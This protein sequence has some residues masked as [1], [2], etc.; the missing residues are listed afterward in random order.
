MSGGSPILV[1]LRGN[2]LALTDREHG[3]NFD[4]DANGVAGRQ[5]WVADGSDDAFLVLD[6]NGNGEV[7]DGAELFGNYTPQPPSHEPNGFLALAVF[8]APRQGGNGDGVID[9]RDA[10]FADLRLWYDRNRDGVSQ[11]DEL[12]PLPD[13]RIVAFELDYRYSPRR[14]R[15]G[16]EFRYVSIVR[17][18]PETPGPRRKLAVDVFFPP[19]H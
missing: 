13:G 10:V 9:D 3:V 4:L 11:S 1:S 6:R 16:N 7:D 2:R 8:D 12:L 19:D 15:Y 17:L 5:P 18:D 14:D